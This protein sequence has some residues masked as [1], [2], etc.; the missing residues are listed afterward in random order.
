M[1]PAPELGTIVVL[2]PNPVQAG[3]MLIQPCTTSV[4]PDAATPA[5]CPHSCANGHGYEGRCLLDPLHEPDVIGGSDQEP[6]RWVWRCW[7][8]DGCAGGL[9][10]GH[11]SAAAARRAYDRHCTDQHTEERRLHAL[12]AHPGWEYAT[13][14]GP[15][16]QWDDAG[17]PPCGDDGLP[18]ETWE[19]NTDA[20][21]DGWERFDYTEESYWRRP[22]AP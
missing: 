14:V 1:A 18:D 22:V 5:E 2:P 16:K 7:G 19:R 15:R 20:G 10:L 6:D 9:S 8:T 3:P 11:F 21:R 12:F 4:P 13:T 17:T